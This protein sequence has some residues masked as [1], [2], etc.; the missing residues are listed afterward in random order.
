MIY[1]DLS[2]FT[3]GLEIPVLLHISHNLCMVIEGF[4]DVFANAND[5]F[6]VLA[7]PRT[8]SYAVE[9]LMQFFF[10]ESGFIFEYVCYRLL[11][12]IFC[13]RHANHSSWYNYIDPVLPLI[14][15]YSL[16]FYFSLPINL[17]LFACVIYSLVYFIPSPV[18]TVASVKPSKNPQVNPLSK[19]MISSQSLGLKSGFNIQAEAKPLARDGNYKTKEQGQATAT[20]YPL[21]D[22]YGIAK[23]V[24]DNIDAAHS[25]GQTYKK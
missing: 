14:L 7:L 22:R 18:L 6:F 16:H 20:A 17:L 9:R 12:Y 21:V 24:L 15:C 4:L 10:D 5:Y 3:R 25:E 1:A 8:A 11:R 13:D 2:Y 19:R 23:A